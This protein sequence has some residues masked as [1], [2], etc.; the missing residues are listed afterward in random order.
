M[1]RVALIARSIVRWGM[2]PGECVRR[3]GA[4]PG[5]CVSLAGRVCQV[6]CVRRSGGGAPTLTR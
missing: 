4:P 6:E 3:F 5:E 2:P 1:R